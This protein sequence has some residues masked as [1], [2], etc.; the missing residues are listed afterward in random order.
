MQYELSYAE[1]QIMD[2]LWRTNDF[3]KTQQILDYA[4]EELGK[5]WKRQTLNT[6]LIRLSQK[7]MIIRE[8]GYVKAKYSQSEWT[9]IKA[10]IFV[11]KNFNGQLN[12][13]LLAYLGDNKKD[14]IDMFIKE[15]IS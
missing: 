10:N 5:N 12:E 1:K 8:R 4:T 15:I 9:H 14:K 13:F 3:I 11:K 7:D 6:L 2:F